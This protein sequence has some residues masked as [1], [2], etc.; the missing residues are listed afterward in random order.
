MIISLKQFTRVAV[1]ISVFIFAAAFIP[2]DEKI[3]VPYPA[4]FRRWAH[5]KSAV[6]LEGHP[7][8]KKYGGYHHIYA[9]EKA[10]Q[11]FTTG[12]FPEGSQIVFDVADMNT[13]NNAIV[14]GNRKFID[15]MYKDSRFAETGGWGYD[16][17]VED[18]ETRAKIDAV[19]CYTCHLSRQKQGYVFSSLRK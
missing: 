16:E 10:M 1:G 5:V 12:T 4:G 17:F 8:F 2:N 13:E 3:E 15:V 6:I 19:A 9:N 7:T 11:G 14:E 18:S